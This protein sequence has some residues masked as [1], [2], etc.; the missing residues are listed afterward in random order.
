MKAY[1]VGELLAK[2]SI[3]AFFVI[4]YCIVSILDFKVLI[5]G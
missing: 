1:Q 5:G 2:I 3:I 4:S